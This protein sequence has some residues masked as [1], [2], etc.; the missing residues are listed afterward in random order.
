MKKIQKLALSFMMGGLALCFASCGSDDDTTFDLPNVGQAT[1]T[2]NSSDLAMQKTTRLTSR[3]WF[4]PLTRLWQRT[5]AN[6]TPPAQR[7]TRQQRL[8]P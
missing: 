8:A 7:S 1:T 4:T 3:M 2:I 6:F 5:H